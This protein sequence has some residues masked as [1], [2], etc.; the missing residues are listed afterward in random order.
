M[1]LAAQCIA[2]NTHLLMRDPDVLQRMPEELVLLLLAMCARSLRL[3]AP[4]V[5]AFSRSG[6]ARVSEVVASLDVHSGIMA[7]APPTPCR[8]L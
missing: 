3:T 8:P 7:A 4:L 5:L 1:R 6:H 2:S